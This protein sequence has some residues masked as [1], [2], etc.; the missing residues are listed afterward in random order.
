MSDDDRAA[1]AA[2]AKALLNK[3]RQQKKP[4]TGAGP[5]TSSTPGSPLVRAFSPPLVDP[6][7]DVKVDVT[8]ILGSNSPRQD[9]SEPEWLS[10]LPRV[11]TPS[12]VSPHEYSL[13][14]SSASSVARSQSPA[15]SGHPDLSLL[16]EP[17][18]R[19]RG[20]ELEDLR[21][22]VQNQRQT[23][24]LL[25]SEKMSLTVSLERLSNVS[26]T[27]SKLEALLQDEQAASER[28][29]L[30]IHHLE[31]ETQ[32]RSATIEELSR[33][34]RG[35]EEKCRENGSYSLTGTLQKG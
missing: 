16:P 28:Y 20:E 6:L 13:P 29:R 3:K 7:E 26:D 15:Q 10:S 23:I 25:V 17:I 35:L 11:G 8:E 32:Q 21:T 9:A 27:A 12:I 2:R 34:E 1:K 18:S 5:S 33:R 24:K 30:R 31:N 4:G 19:A 14:L 22:E